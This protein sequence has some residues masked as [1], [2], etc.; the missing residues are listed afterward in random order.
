MNIH[1]LTTPDEKKLSSTLWCRDK[2]KEMFIRDFNKVSKTT[3]DLHFKDKGNSRS[4]KFQELEGVI[5][6]NG[7]GSS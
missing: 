2:I 4:V 6:K 7:S 3:K 5:F 1:C